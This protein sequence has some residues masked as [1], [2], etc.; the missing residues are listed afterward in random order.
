[1][2][3]ESLPGIQECDEMIIR[4]NRVLESL[5]RIREVIV[6]Q[7]IALAEQ[8]NQERRYKVTPSE[9]DDD[10]SSYQDKMDGGGFG[11]SDSKKRRGVCPFWS[12]Y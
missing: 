5:N 2:T 8:Q 10:A 7:K 12:V 9:F 1:M 11:G 6:A 4:Q 3:A